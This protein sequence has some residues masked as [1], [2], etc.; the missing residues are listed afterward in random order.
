MGRE[1]RRL[2][3]AQE[4]IAAL[5][6]DRQE[7]PW[8]DLEPQE[9]HY[10]ERV[11]RYHPGD[12]LALVDG[13]GQL[14]TA[15]LEPERRLRL[16]QPPE[17]PLLREPAVTPPLVLAMAVPKREADLVWRMATELGANQLQPLL[18]QR[19]APGERCPLDRWRGIV[20]E[21][22]EQC[23]RLWH[24]QLESPCETRAWLARPAPG[25][26]LLAT[27]RRDGLPLCSQRLRQLAEG[28]SDRDLAAGIRLAI[29]PEG[30]WS[31]EEEERA[32]S[33][34][35]HPVSLGGSILRTATAAVGGLALL[36]DWR[37]LRSASCRPPSP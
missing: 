6:G 4:R 1:L 31:P 28:S 14:W 30:G 17:A 5:A 26:S 33:A 10:L 18:A 23:E 13:V 7:L 36:A 22:T 27:T 2:L 29:G 21:A 24:P 16:E 12:R 32:E 8:L 19:S 25:I 11:L 9:G 34:G 35:W 15:V 20:R 3:I 37:A